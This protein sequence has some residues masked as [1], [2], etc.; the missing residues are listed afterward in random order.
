MPT[1]DWIG[2][3]AVE[4]YRKQVPVHLLRC[5]EKLSVGDAGSGNLL[6]LGDNL[7]ALKALLPF[8][9][10]QVKC[11]YID[12][13]YNTGNEGWIYNDAVNSPEMKEWLGKAV[14]GEAEDLSRHDKWLCMMQP[15]LSLL[16]QFLREDGAIFISIDDNELA[17]LR[18]LMDDIF[19]ARNLV[20]ILCWQKRVSPANDA[21]YFSSDHEY[22]VV[23]AL[24]KERWRP[25][26]LE[27]SEGQLDNYR[28]PDNDERGPWNS[29]TYTCNKSRQE[30]PNL[31]HGITNPNT[32]EVIFPKETAVWKY[33][34]ER[35]KRNEEEGLVYWGA[36]GR[37]KMP[38]LKKFLAGARDVVPRSV[39]LYDDYGHTQEARSELLRIIENV[40]F[41]TPKPIRLL[42]KLLQIGADKDSLVLDSFAG[43]GTTGHAV[44]GLNK[45][46][47]GSR[48]FILV[49]MEEQICRPVTVQRLEK[50]ING[51]GHKKSD[52]K[53]ELVPGLGTGFRFCTLGRPLFD[54]DGSINAQVRFNDLASY[55]YFAETGEPLPKRANGKTPLL[56]EHNGTA[57]YLLYN[58]ILG[59]KTPH[60]GNVL[61][62]AV[63][64]LLPAHDGPKVVY[65]TSCRLGE[66]R[67]RREGIVF[68]QIPY[69][70]RV[71]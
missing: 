38:R 52:G 12:P 71:G 39:L 34:A 19:G 28:N 7:V 27:R 46:D 5:D 58:G 43:S 17:N 8:Y 30:R 4:N 15:R 69:E 11:I 68:R 22:V 33:D 63:L 61:T 14:G 36:D 49:E 40:P 59:D 67:L 10:G 44:L 45:A 50:A 9:S 53:Q 70:V 20:A 37:A 1:L 23:Y 55:V 24:Q 65:G 56:G 3:K 41:T 16:R 26:R 2:K 66:E 54:A 25:N 6:I 31:Y 21:K 57:I 48:K 51:Y 60:G 42:Q 13:P 18:F 35:H 62:R 64:G 32:G 47:G 29:A